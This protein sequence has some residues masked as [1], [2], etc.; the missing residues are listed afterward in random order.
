MKAYTWSQQAWGAE[1]SGR[2]KVWPW[3]DKCGQA[4]D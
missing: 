3:L 4:W 2:E 1:Q